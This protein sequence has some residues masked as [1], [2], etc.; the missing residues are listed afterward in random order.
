MSGQSIPGVRIPSEFPSATKRD[1]NANHRTSDC[2]HPKSAAQRSK[3]GMMRKSI[4]AREQH[5]DR[6]GI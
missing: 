5:C 4:A 2:N 6:D 1:R 3:T